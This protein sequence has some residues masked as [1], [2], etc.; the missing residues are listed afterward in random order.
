MQSRKKKIVFIGVI[1]VLFLGMLGR[2]IAIYM[3]RGI[4]SRMVYKNV[5]G[6][7]YYELCDGTYAICNCLPGDRMRAIAIV[8]R[9]KKL[10]AL[11]KAEEVED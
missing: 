3:K 11:L 4:N 9:N 2:G 10:Y 6:Y 8:D 5:V 7:T 1:T